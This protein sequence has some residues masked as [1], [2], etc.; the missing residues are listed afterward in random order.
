MFQVKKDYPDLYSTSRSD[1][2]V[3]IK[4]PE[5]CYLSL[6]GEGD[7]NAKAFAVNIS[8]LFQAFF[9]LKGETKK[10][11]AAF[12]FGMAP[13]E[14]LWSTGTADES[15]WEGGAGRDKS[16]WR[17]RLLLALPAGFPE[18]LLRAVQQK[19]KQRRPALAEITDKI[20]LFNLEEGLCYQALHIGSYDNETPLINA[21]TEK[22]H[23]DGFRRTGLHHE[24]YL[25]GMG[26]LP[27][28]TLLRQ[29]AMP[30]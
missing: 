25:R 21:I 3:Q 19:L 22:M 24:I 8:C 9:A 5:M 16:A 7:P 18:E 29:P 11:A 2:I 4:V 30:N 20:T 13:I 26:P 10:F 27:K 14:A 15:S 23:A 1:G 6:E 12:S 28:K 17:Y